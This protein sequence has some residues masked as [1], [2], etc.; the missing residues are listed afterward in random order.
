MGWLRRLG[1][2]L[3]P[4]RAA[5]AFDE[6]TRFHVDELIDDLVR[7]GLTPEDARREARRRFGNVSAV[8]ERTRDADV[9]RWLGDA[10]QDLRFAA[11]TLIRSPGFTLVAVVT[12]ALGIGANTAIF[13]LFDAVLLR[14][15]PV[16]EPSRLVLFSD[17]DGEGASSGSPPTGR[18]IEFSTEVYRHLAGS[19]HDA[20]LG[21]ASLAAV[22][23]GETTV[24]VRQGAA[25]PQRAQ[26]HLVS[27]NYFD[28]MGAAIARGRALTADDDR[29]GAAPA[30]VVSDLFWQK[31]LHSDAGAVGRSIT[32]NRTAFTIVG[33]APPEFFGERVR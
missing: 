2:T 18:W 23:S 10:T 16:R 22:R 11:R 1:N 13:T 3:L 32:L 21:F 15:L 27:G 6:E 33:V 12:L 17:D 30:A 5:R 24:L 4:G 28:T 8:R 31:T 7:D 14:P 29:T 9:H 20:S 26:A 25:Q 19:N